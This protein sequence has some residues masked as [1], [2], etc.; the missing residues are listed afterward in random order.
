M[1]D[2]SVLAVRADLSDLT[3]Y[4]SPQRPAQ[5]R[6]NTNESPYA[7]PPQLLKEA[8]EELERRELNRY[9]DHRA[10]SLLDAV[11]E[12]CDWP[13][14]G[15]WIA[16]GSNEVFLHF[17]LA[18]GGP[19]R[20]VLVFEPTY[21]VHATIARIA[22]THVVTARRTGSFGIELDSAQA[23][24]A[25]ERPEIVMVCSPNNP[26]GNCESVATIE[27]LLEAAPGIVVVDE[28][29]IEFASPEASVRGLLEKHRNLVIVRTLSKAWRLAGVRLGYALADPAIAQEIARVRLPYHLSTFTQAVGVAALRRSAEALEFVA[30]ITRERARIEKELEAMRVTV[31][32]SS[33][34]FTLF[35]LPDARRAWETLLEGGVLV[36]DYSR[37]PG[38][39][40]CLRVTA[41]L[42]EETDAFLTV[43]K[44]VT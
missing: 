28:A 44:E 27:A 20:S 7:P 15:L 39:T 16:N 1:T 8:V 23:V 42:P 11:S 14:E 32:P 36:R 18:F 35:R 21:S 43:M 31:F 41:G 30:A 38:L 26:T 9:P 3:P 19:G 12:Y 13:P 5:F 29:Y 24:I 4:E 22:G 40:D 25:S 34:N 6:M 17:F 37:S 10:K 2:R 33:A